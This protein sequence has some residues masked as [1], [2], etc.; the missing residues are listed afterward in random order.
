MVRGNWQRRVEK[1]EAR[2]QEAKQ[3]KHRQ[4]S[5]K[6]F[7]SQA[8]EFMGFLD[9]YSSVWKKKQVIH[10][11][12]D[13][14][15]SN[16]PPILD[17][18]DVHWDGDNGG[19]ASSGSRHK[20]GGKRG[21]NRSNTIESEGSSTGKKKVH[22]RSRET[23]HVDE[24]P[25]DVEV[26]S[27][28]CRSHFFTGKC[29]FSVGGKKGNTKCRYIHQKN[30][31]TLRDILTQASNGK[32]ELVWSEQAL[33]DLTGTY[34]TNSP[35][36]GNNKATEDP[37]MDMV[38]H[39][40]IAVQDLNSNPDRSM[41]ESIGEALTRQGCSVGSIVYF[42]IDDQLLYDRHRDGT[43]LDEQ[44][45]NS[46]DYRRQSSADVQ[47]VVLLLPASIL[48]HALTFLEDN[49]V[50]AMCAV[51][52]AWHSEIGR[53]SSN[54]WK[55][56][57]LRRNWP[58][59]TTE[60]NDEMDDKEANPSKIREE[61]LL[62][63]ETF[64]SHYVAVRDVN[65]IKSG[66]TAMIFRKSMDDREGCFRSF[67][68]IRGSPQAGNPC[69]TTKIWSPNRV[70]VA[71]F[72]DCTI[73]L[74]DSVERSGANGNR[75]CRELVSRSMDPYLRTKKRCCNFIDMALDE[76]VIGCLLH[77][78]EDGT[79]AE[80]NVLTILSR[81]DF[82]MHDETAETETSLQVVDVGQSVLNYLLSCDDVGHGLLQLHDFL[83]D[84][85]DLDDVEVLISPNLVA[86][87]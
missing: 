82:L 17:M 45:M 72:Q 67:E 64:L 68:S 79:Q 51:C 71:Y 19:H 63:K 26:V 20:S 85:G 66:I 13:T 15:P 41:S 16:A 29:N 1:T 33:P 36:D 10:V 57:L 12:T 34:D 23:A 25:G 8:H 43:L 59:P 55:H 52:K 9:R 4:E 78:V 53:Q 35:G 11:W 76:E 7:K 75:V 28:L 84:G 70:L 5:K 46:G 73:R 44:G 24:N 18:R 39:L 86:C 3:R 58:L 87:G 40:S 54:L 60:D 48:E 50:A 2:R 37:R 38:Y 31:V 69:V 27:Y 49:A 32:E 77:V 83:R 42:V 56:L 47:E 65:A 61:L 80:A 30:S 74:F 22:P 62:L 6:M 81:D 14:I 21:R